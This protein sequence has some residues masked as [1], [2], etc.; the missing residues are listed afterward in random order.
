MT[1]QETHDETKDALIGHVPRTWVDEEILDGQ[2]PDK[3]LDKRLC[4]V[5]DQLGGA[6]GQTIPQACQDWANT[7]AAYRFFVTAQCARKLA[8]SSRWKSGPG[9]G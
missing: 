9:K 1:K 7:K 8:G 5:F 3:R 4:Q 6:L 2:L